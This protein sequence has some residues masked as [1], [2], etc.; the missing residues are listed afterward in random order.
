M[1]ITEMMITEVAEQLNLDPIEI[2]QKNMYKLNDLTPFDAPIKDWYIPEMWENLIKDSNY[3]QK[4]EEIDLFNRENKWKKRGLSIIP[5]KFGISFGARFLNQAGALVHIY[6]DGTIL[7]SHC[8]IEMGQG[9][10]TKMCQ[11]AASVLDVPIEKIFISETSTDKVPN[12]SPSAASV[13][14]DINGMAVMNACQQLKERLQPYKDKNPNGSI[15][16]WAFAAYFDRVNLSANGFYKTPDLS[17]DWETG[18]GILYFY[19]TTGVAMSTVELDLLTGDHT[20]MRS[21]IVMDIGNSIN[22]PIDIGQIE[23][24]FMQGVGW[25]TNEEVLLLTGNGCLFTRGPGN[26]KIPSF[27]DIPVEFNVKILRDKEY[28]SLKTVQS[29]KGIG[30]PPLFLC[31]SVFFAL[32]DA[33][34]SARKANG[35]NEPLLNFQS[36]CTPEILRLAIKDELV[37]R[38]T[39]LPKII[40]KNQGKPVYV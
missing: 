12:G 25:C 3:K 11:I 4:R 36:P 19:F 1:M 9:L 23:G 18:K 20:I 14:S 28:N 30:E 38:S 16:D 37:E 40:E 27:R 32:R 21:D 15:S 39:V 5:T 31:S 26:Y 7:I 24:A 2:R 13:S 17:F 35:V 6:A 10:H 22:Y 33:V 34:V 8:G 29:S